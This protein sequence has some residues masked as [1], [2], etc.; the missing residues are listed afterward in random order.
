M[1]RFI[2]SLWQMT[3]PANGRKSAA[4]PPARSLS[5]PT[6]G[7]DDQG[8][9]RDKC[10]HWQQQALAKKKSKTGFPT[11]SPELGRFHQTL[12]SS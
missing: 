8:V 7:G 1:D 3:L 12:I 6:L 10:E 5:G 9:S 2:P 11:I 4:G